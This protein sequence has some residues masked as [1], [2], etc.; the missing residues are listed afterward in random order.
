MRKLIDPDP[1]CTAVR[2]FQIDRFGSFFIDGQRQSYTQMR[3]LARADGFA[4][5]AEMRGWFRDVHGVKDR[6]IFD[7]VLIEWEPY[8]E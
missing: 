5:L 1:V 7:G 3:A 6:K 8:H 2:V 4:C